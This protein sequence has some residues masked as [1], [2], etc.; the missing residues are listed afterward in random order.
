MK[1]NVKLLHPFDFFVRIYY[2]LLIIN[3]L[4]AEKFIGLMGLSEELVKLS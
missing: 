1:I 3:K 2:I 4:M